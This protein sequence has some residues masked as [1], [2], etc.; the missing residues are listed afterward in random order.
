MKKAAK[1]TA[2]TAGTTKT[3]FISNRA[4]WLDRERIYNV[5][6]WLIGSPTNI[7]LKTYGV[8]GN[9]LSFLLLVCSAD[10]R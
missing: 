7:V 5:I 1:T 4:C 2:R 8:R 6:P 3:G 10:P 9:E